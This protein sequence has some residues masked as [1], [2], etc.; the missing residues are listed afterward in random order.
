MKRNLFFA[1]R[2]R[3]IASIK[4]A[5]TGSGFEEEKIGNATKVDSQEKIQIERKN[6]LF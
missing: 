6:T 1:E 4:D 2:L 5:E 3:N